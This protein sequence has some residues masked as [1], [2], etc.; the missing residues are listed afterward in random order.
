MQKVKNRIA[1]DAFRRLENPFF[2]MLQLL[3]YDGL[4]DWNYINEWADRTLAVTA[5]DVK[6][7]A[8]KY[9]DKPNRAGA[10]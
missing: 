3:F 2:L 7:V 6:R 8:G 1:A 9:F 4:G 5:D 10:L